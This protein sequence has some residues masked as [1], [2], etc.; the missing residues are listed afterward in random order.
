MFSTFFLVFQLN[1]LQIS[2]IVQTF[3]CSYLCHLRMFCKKKC[4]EK[5]LGTKIPSKVGIIGP[6]MR[7]IK[8]FKYKNY[9]L[10]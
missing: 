5:S 9:F 2:Y 1:N 3:E 4:A 7:G 8:F 6:N 10:K